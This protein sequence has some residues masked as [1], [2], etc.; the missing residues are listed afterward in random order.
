LS[1]S[2]AHAALKNARARRI[3]DCFPDVELPGWSG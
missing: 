1:F 2:A 3:M